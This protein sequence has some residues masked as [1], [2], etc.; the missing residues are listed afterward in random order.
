MKIRN[1]EKGFYGEYITNKGNKVIFDES[2]AMIDHVW[3][4]NKFY[5]VYTKQ[6]ENKNYILK[7][8]ELP[9][10]YKYEME[11][12]D[13]ENNISIP[14]PIAIRVN[15]LDMEPTV[16]IETKEFYKAIKN[17]VTYENDDE[18]VVAC[19]TEAGNI[20]VPVGE[21][22]ID[23]IVFTKCIDIAGRDISD[24]EEKHVLSVCNFQKIVS[25][26]GN[27][28]YNSDYSRIS[29][30]LNTQNTDELVFSKSDML[31][32]G[33]KDDDYYFEYKNGT[34]QKLF[35]KYI[36]GIKIAMLEDITSF[37][38]SMVIKHKTRISKKTTKGITD[39]LSSNTFDWIKCI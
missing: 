5:N 18:I 14:E 29:V 21:E 25:F 30:K 33:T 28:K 20:L 38:T 23:N 22:T 10:T 35:V 16:K 36:Q 9:K 8:T 26:C 17:I 15:I 27:I 31:M 34:K 11:E 2:F 37:P 12:E 3:I 4:D 24:Y 1:K 6:I 32:I 13:M 7:I 39:K 19:S